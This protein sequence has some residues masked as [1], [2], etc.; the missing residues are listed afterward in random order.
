M[1]I[2]IRNT[3][4][5]PTVIVGLGETGLSCVR[6]LLARKRDVVVVDS[7][8]QPPKLSALHTEF[9]DVPLYLG[10]FDEDVLGRAKEIILSPGV[11][12]QEP[13]IERVMELGVPVIGDIELFARE[14]H[15]SNARGSIIAVTGSNGK[16]TVTSLVAEMAR[17]DG[18]TIR[19]GGNLGPPALALLGE[20]GE[21]AEL[22]VL[23]LSS[24]QLETTTSLNPIA[25]TI[26]NLSE[27]HMDRYVDMSSYAKAKCRIFAGDGA[28]VLNLDDPMVV[29][30]RSKQAGLDRDNIRRII[31]FTLAVPG[32]D[33]FGVVDRDG[34]A[35]IAYGETPLLPISALRLQG[36]HNVAN[37][38]AAL[39]LG[40]AAG[41][42]LAAMRETLREFSGLPHRC[43]LVAE[44]NDV[45]WFN[46]SKA[47]NVGATVAAI[48]GLGR[49]EGKLVLIAGGDGKGADFSPLGAAIKGDESTAQETIRAMVLLGRDAD[50]IATV[51][52]GM[53]PI[54]YVDDMHDAVR[55]ARELAHP[56]DS[57][58]LSPACA[59]W[60]MY[61]DYRERGKLFT[62]EVNTEGA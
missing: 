48:R 5:R 51:V 44:Y 58:L 61:R 19:V 42:S 62:N 10:G 17:M 45:R 43:Q 37:A 50:R 31:G 23:E 22:F 36:M 35:W 2:E 24:F 27:D 38:L 41:L 21:E 40:M 34:D 56:G 54:V 33:E 47:T 30:M 28:I 49:Q 13:A 46:D 52:Q 39:A 60:D 12:L 20:E 15:A 32:V 8:E 53:I 26:L 9:S 57:V 25:A 29:A 16:S 11:S 7:R 18:R 55:Q 59:S 1:G 6:Y 4:M 3:A 14:L